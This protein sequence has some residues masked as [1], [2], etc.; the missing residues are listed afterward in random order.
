LYIRGSDACPNFI[1]SDNEVRGGALQ[2]LPTGNGRNPLPQRRLPA[3]RTVSPRDPASR[4]REWM[5]KC[6]HA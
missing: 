4:L 5:R 2:A 6:S 1:L 3:D